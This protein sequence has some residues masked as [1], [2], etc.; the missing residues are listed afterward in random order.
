[1]ATCPYLSQE[2]TGCPSK[3][4]LALLIWLPHKGG[5]NNPR[6]PHFQ[7]LPGAVREKGLGDD[8]CACVCREAGGH[9]GKRL[10]GNRAWRT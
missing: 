1:M 2:G 10:L 7:C 3:P 5:S 4:Q 8:V 6:G 9:K